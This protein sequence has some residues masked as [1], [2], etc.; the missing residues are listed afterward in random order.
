M[1]DDELRVLDEALKMLSGIFNMPIDE[2]RYAAK[3][4]I[5]REDSLYLHK[6]NPN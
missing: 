1:T 3:E 4:E 6:V 2:L 5:R